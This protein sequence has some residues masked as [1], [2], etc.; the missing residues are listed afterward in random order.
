MT[1]KHIVFYS[2][3]LPPDYIGGIETNAYYMV[4]ALSKMPDI[5]LSVVSAG[6]R[7]FFRRKK[8][9]HFADGIAE[10]VYLLNKKERGQPASLLKKFGD[11]G[12][13][14]EQTLIYHNTL[15]LQACYKALKGQ[16]YF[17]LARSGGNDLFFHGR[18]DKEMRE[19][20]LSNLQYLDRLIV[21]SN[22]SQGRCREL[23]LDL[24]NIAVIKGGCSFES[25]VPLQSSSDDQLDQSQPVILSCG[26]MVDFKGFAD[27][28]EAMGLVKDSGHK[29]HYYLVGAGELLP[30]LQEK[31]IDMGLQDC[32]FF[33][34]KQPPEKIPVLYQQADLYL[35]SSKDIVRS[36]GDTQYIH[37]ETM[38]RSI[39]E[40]QAYGLPVVSTDAGGSPEMLLPGETGLVVKQG[41]PTAIAEAVIRMLS[42]PEIRRQFAANAQHYAAASLSWD[43]VVQQTLQLMQNIKPH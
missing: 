18:K 34:G 42:A 3:N 41:D 38:G 39:C 35:S 8:T 21:N 2:K 27:A 12:F 16:G 15:D 43:A 17:Q 26:R 11:F 1:I 7:T 23:G 19:I 9:Y 33:L 32:V 24:D 5:T 10:K 36:Q 28:I 30:V 14:P 40:A 31:V 4:S 13:K 25:S 22:Y 29:F 6:R 20:F 37:T